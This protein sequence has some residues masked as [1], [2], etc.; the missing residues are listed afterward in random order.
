M[1]EA[2]DDAAA[3]LL[4]RAVGPETG[5]GTGSETQVFALCD[6]AGCADEPPAGTVVTRPLGG[7]GTVEVCSVAVAPGR[8]GCGLDGRLLDEVAHA[9]LA[10]GARRMVARADPADADRQL[11]L[12]RA[13]F[14]PDPQ[15]G[16]PPDGDARVWFSR[17]L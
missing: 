16:P 17:E 5:T 9:L 13:G 2:T 1:L 12:R 8:Q 11:L 6:L 4:F 10:G 14:R 7:D 15:A 3:S